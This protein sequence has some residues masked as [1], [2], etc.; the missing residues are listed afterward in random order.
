MFI[1]N[2]K[3]T[4][5]IVTSL[6]E[7]QFHWLKCVL[8]ANHPMESYRGVSLDEH[9][10]TIDNDTI[11]DAIKNIRVGYSYDLNKENSVELSDEELTELIQKYG[12][13]ERKVEVYGT[14]TRDFD[15]T[16]TVPMDKN[17]D[18]LHHL[19]EY[20]LEELDDSFWWN[21]D[22]GERQDSSAEVNTITTKMMFVLPTPTEFGFSGGLKEVA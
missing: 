16:I 8:G 20:D 1:E 15:T 17:V 10:D 21:V 9:Y 11:A 5:E 13:L 6:T 14:V 22:E 3:K 7:D 2:E 19:D 4:V 12:H 18:E